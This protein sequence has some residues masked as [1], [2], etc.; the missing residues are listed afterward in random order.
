MQFPSHRTLALPVQRVISQ[1]DPD[2]PVSDVTTL[3][4]AIGKS[5]INSEF[6]STDSGRH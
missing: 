2:L 3:R 4:E 1:L 5:T 6:S